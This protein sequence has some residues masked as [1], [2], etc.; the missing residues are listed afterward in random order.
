MVLLYATIE[1]ARIYLLLIF[2]N[3]KLKG[4]PLFVIFLTILI[5][6]L[7]VGILV[8][9]IPVLLADPSSKD[10]LLPSTMTLDQG[11]VILGF[12]T[13]IYPIMQF[14]A[15]PILGQLSDKYGR[16][17]L[18]AISLSGT[19]ISYV[20]F[21]IGI[22]TKNIPLLFIS[23]GF[24]GIT[25][26]NIAVAQAATADITTPENR[27]KN[28]GL[29]GAAFG[30]GFVV[31]PYIGG[32]LSDPSFVSWFNAAT[33]FWFAAILSFI[34]VLFVF[35]MFPETLK[36]LKKDVK[37]IW[38][39]SVANIIRAANTKELRVVFASFFLANAG[40]TF[41][42]TFASIFLI[43]RF[44]F[45]QGNIGDYFAFIGLCSILSQVLVV[46]RLG[47]K[48]KE[49]QIL[50]YSFFAWALVTLLFLLPRETWQLLL[51]TPLMPLAIS[52]TQ[53]NVTS[54]VSKSATAEIQGEILGINSS[55]MALAQSIPPILSGYIAASL[56][57]EAP[58][59]VAAVVIAVGAVMFAL[60]YDKTHY[61]AGSGEEVMVAG[62]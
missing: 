55:V 35:F 59:V 17:K 1:I 44:G 45:D 25:G 20:L 54:L 58:L 57:E 11:F 27:V 48:F 30:F 51:L 19:A 50:K 8:P 31:G 53:T 36:N 28:F 47:K 60:F 38:N 49:Y 26:G 40:F 21:A 3:S 23:R 43:N 12:L 2:M 29:M 7:G 42:T 32:K 13:A 14:L 18:L 46:G 24:D 6:M 10:F 16:R 39:K 15:A 56:T 5:D 34:D 22:L 52:L 61:K 4:K 62:H 9:V 33:P 41:F 37:I